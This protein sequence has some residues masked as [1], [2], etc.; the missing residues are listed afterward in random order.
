[1]WLKEL[2]ADDW[3][4]GRISRHTLRL[5]AWLH[6][7]TSLLRYRSRYTGTEV[8]FNWSPDNGDAITVSSDNWQAHFQ[9]SCWFTEHFPFSVNTLRY[10]LSSFLSQE[11]MQNAILSKQIILA[12]LNCCSSVGIDS[13]KVMQE[14]RDFHFYLPPAYKVPIEP[15]EWLVFARLTIERMYDHTPNL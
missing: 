2:R 1:M 15:H 12:V 9:D 4:P 5:V 7:R 10:F 14:N 8:S 13:D 11:C 6:K 3:R